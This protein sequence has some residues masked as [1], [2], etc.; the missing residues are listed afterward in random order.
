MPVPI[1]S[2]LLESCRVSLFGFTDVESVETIFE[3]FAGQAPSSLSSDRR[4]GVASASGSWKAGVLQVASGPGRVDLMYGPNA[5]EVPEVVFLDGPP[6]ARFGDLC[7]A[8]S[9]WA[10]T[11]SARWSRVALGAKCMLRTDSVEQTY[12]Y[13]ANLVRTVH[14]DYPRMKEMT[15]RANFQTTSTVHEG[16]QINRISGWNSITY[17]RSVFS[18]VGQAIRS[19]PLDEMFFASCEIDFNTDADRAEP[20]SVERVA[21]LICELQEHAESCLM[22][23]VE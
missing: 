11:S 12:Q 19:V 6:N 7:S 3:S 17:R 10:K 20:F 8:T 18:P 2:W 13:L 9:A 16:L 5:P 1:E 21:D 22:N 15:F 23:G 14:V 4:A